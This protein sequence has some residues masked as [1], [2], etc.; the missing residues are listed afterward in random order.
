M[1]ESFARQ[2]LVFHRT[3]DRIHR[4]SVEKEL[5]VDCFWNR[6]HPKRTMVGFAKTYL[7]FFLVFHLRIVDKGGKPL[8]QYFF[9]LALDLRFD[10][11][12]HNCQILLCPLLLANEER[13]ENSFKVC[14]ILKCRTP[15]MEVSSP[16]AS[17]SLSVFI[18]DMG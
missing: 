10:V 12:V 5:F 16:V 7:S 15:I 11:P 13:K 2:S 6:P 14:E 3:W 8:S 9:N 4:T 18:Y 1:T 17:G